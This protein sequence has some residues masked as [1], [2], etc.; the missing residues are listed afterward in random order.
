[1]G[2]AILDVD[3]P[4][5]RGYKRIVTRHYQ[6]LLA[7]KKIDCIVAAVR[8]RCDGR[9]R[10][11]NGVFGHN[12]GLGLSDGQRIVLSQ[13]CSA[14]GRIFADHK[15]VT[16]SNSRTKAEIVFWRTVSLEVDYD[17]QKLQDL[18]DPQ[19]VL[20]AIGRISG[21]STRHGFAHGQRP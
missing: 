13:E 3:F 5:R 12:V 6:E 1:V 7:N 11:E 14:V 19:W 8:R 10:A 2:V 16:V 15:V 17:E 4:T 18:L 21:G 20:S 9:S